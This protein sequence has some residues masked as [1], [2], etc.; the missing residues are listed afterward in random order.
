MATE[1]T[2]VINTVLRFNTVVSETKDKI[3]SETL[4]EKGMLFR[5]VID[6]MK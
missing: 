6:M 1:F 4:I 3:H 5:K 2:S